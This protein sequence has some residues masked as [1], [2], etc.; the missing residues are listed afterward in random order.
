M[1]KATRSRLL[2]A[3]SRGTSKANKAGYA[4]RKAGDRQSPVQLAAIRGFTY[5]R[6][7]AVAYRLKQPLDTCM[8]N[9]GCARQYDKPKESNS[10][11]SNNNNNNDED[12]DNDDTDNVFCPSLVIRSCRPYVVTRG[13]RGHLTDRAYQNTLPYFHRRCGRLTGNTHKRLSAVG[14]ASTCRHATSRC[15]AVL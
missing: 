14:V 6:F 11:N 13:A 7:P 1:G 4:V 12:E 15:A 10:S 5:W 8:F 3:G 9:S 2:H